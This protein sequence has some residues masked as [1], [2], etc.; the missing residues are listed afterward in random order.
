M[1]AHQISLS[2]LSLLYISCTVSKFHVNMHDESWSKRKLLEEKLLTISH[3]VECLFCVGWQAR[4]VD[5][6]MTRFIV[7]AGYLILGC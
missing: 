1:D 2:T 7:V 6:N 4:H 3:E 5:D